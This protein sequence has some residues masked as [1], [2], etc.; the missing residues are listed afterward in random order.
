MTLGECLR[1]EY[2][3]KQCLEYGA[4]KLLPAQFRPCLESTPL[5]YFLQMNRNKN[6][7][8]SSKD[9]GQNKGWH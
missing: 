9:N 4:A 8:L 2:N 7:S 1:G 3:W 5:V 6:S